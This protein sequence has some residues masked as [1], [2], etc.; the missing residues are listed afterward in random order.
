MN[1]RK[2]YNNYYNYTLKDDDVTEMVIAFLN[3]EENLDKLIELNDIGIQPALSFLCLNLDK[4]YRYKECF[5][6]DTYKQY[7][8]TLFGAAFYELGYSKKNSKEI[9]VDFLINNATL[10]KK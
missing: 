3:K 6:S 4:I 2:K 1:L 10:F 5:T 8:G 9:K 7:F